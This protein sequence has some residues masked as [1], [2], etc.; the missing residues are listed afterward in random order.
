MRLGSAWRTL[1]IIGSAYQTGAERPPLTSVFSARTSATQNLHQKSAAMSG[2]A[3]WD[4]WKVNMSTLVESSGRRIR[5]GLIPVFAAGMLSALSAP[6][7]ADIVYDSTITALG[8]G[9]GA[10]PRMLTVDQTGTGTGQESACDGNVGGALSIGQCSGQDATFQGNGWIVPNS[11]DSVNGGK[12]ALVTLS[13]V[14]I[15]NANQIV[16]IYNP[17]QEGSSPWTDIVDLTLKFYDSS[18]NIFF[19]VDGGC[20]SNC[21]FSATDP[22]YFGDTGVNLGNG[23][24]GFALTLDATQAAA[25]NAAC[26]L[27]MIN[28]VTMA[29]ET[30]IANANDGPESFYLYN[31]SQVPEPLT[32]TLFGAGLLGAVGIRRKAKKT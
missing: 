13:S 3:A 24:A 32:L 26:G 6:A 29:L 19:S 27:N 4:S 9:F 8:Q 16:L 20:G 23:G 15:T 18:N 25:V 1:A 10:V 5:W 28:C 11:A 12:D 14:S 7:A 30:T 31:R 17:S 2:L 21:T 22:L